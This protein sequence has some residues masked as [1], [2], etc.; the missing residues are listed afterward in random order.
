VTYGERY[1]PDGSW[2]VPVPPIGP[3]S[4]FTWEADG[5]VDVDARGIAFFSFFCPPKRLGTGQFYVVTFRDGT[6]QR[7]RGGATYRL[8]VPADVPVH[9][10]WSVTAYHTWPRPPGSSSLLVTW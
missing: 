7:L 5:L 10:F 3:Q 1:W 8:R 4:G 9:Q 2:D 6:G